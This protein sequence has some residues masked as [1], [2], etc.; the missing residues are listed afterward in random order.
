MQSDDA[1]HEDQDCCGEA[2]LDDNHNK[3]IKVQVLNQH[4]QNDD[5]ASDCEEVDTLNRKMSVH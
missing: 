5:E 2:G 1:Y 3:V 4:G